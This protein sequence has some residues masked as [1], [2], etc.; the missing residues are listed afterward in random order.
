MGDRNGPFSG[1]KCPT[2]QDFAYKISTFSG[3]IPQTPIAQHS[4][5]WARDVATPGA[6]WP[7]GAWTQTPISLW[8]ASVP[9]VRSCFAKRPLIKRNVCSASTNPH[10][11]WAVWRCSLDGY[12]SITVILWWLPFTTSTGFYYAT[13]ING[14]LG[15]YKQKGNIPMAHEL[16]NNF[17][18]KFPATP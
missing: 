13:E 8:L 11:V 15:S 16:F 2:L 9:I 10:F 14:H 17:S 5:R 18:T 6:L 7:P 1:Q 12:H 4:L 3:V